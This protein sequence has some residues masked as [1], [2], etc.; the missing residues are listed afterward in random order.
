MARVEDGNRHLEART[1]EE[2]LEAC[3]QRV[4]ESL[5]DVDMESFN[6]GPFLQPTATAPQERRTSGQGLEDRV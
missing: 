5:R 6:D 1:F 3:K 4:P 2:Y